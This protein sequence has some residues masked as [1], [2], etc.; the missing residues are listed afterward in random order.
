MIR[1]HFFVSKHTASDLYL[2]DIH[3]HVQANAKITVR[4]RYLSKYIRK[5]AFFCYIHAQIKTIFSWGGEEPT[6]DQGRPDKV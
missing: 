3:V 4:Y 6:S 1:F 2:S 5:Y